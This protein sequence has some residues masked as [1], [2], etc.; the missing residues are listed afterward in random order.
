MY[1]FVTHYDKIDWLSNENSIV[2]MEGLM[3]MEEG[4]HCT[5]L[6]RALRESGASEK[7]FQRKKEVPYDL[8]KLFEVGRVGEL[9]KALLINRI[10]RCGYSQED[11][12][13]D[14]AKIC[15][16][17]QFHDVLSLTEQQFKEWTS[18]EGI[19]NSLYELEKN[20]ITHKQ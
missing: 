19:S 6:R 3:I 5:N 17:W 11:A 12:T 13:K 14:F 8:S 18:G 20:G 7:I 9:S 15:I 10:I 2:Y 4:K 1:Y 16:E